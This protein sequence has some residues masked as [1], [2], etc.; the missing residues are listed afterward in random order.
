M[1]WGSNLLYSDFQQFE[2]NLMNY[3]HTQIGYITIAALGAVII[4]IIAQIQFFGSA[5]LPIVVLVILVAC[6]LMFSSLTIEIRGGFLTWKLGF[7]LIHKKVPVSD[8][9]RATPIK[10]TLLQGWGIHWT[11]GF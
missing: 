10:T 7:G 1:V 11:P 8:I 9:I 3:H 6:L 5:P 4:L 2:V